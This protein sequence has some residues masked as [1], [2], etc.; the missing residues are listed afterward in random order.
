MIT[1]HRGSLGSEVVEYTECSKSW[2]KYGV[3]TSI[4]LP[5]LP[6]DLEAEAIERTTLKS[7]YLYLLN[8]QL[9]PPNRTPQAL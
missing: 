7:D 8:E 1:S 6:E 9:W 4:D 5:K 2:L 3:I